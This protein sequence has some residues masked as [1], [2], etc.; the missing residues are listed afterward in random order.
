MIFRLKVSE[1]MENMYSWIPK[2]EIIKHFNTCIV[3]GI[4]GHYK[5]L[6]KIT[7]RGTLPLRVFYILSKKNKISLVIF[8][9]G[10]AISSPVLSGHSKVQNVKRVLIKPLMNPKINPGLI[11]SKYLYL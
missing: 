8:S 10:K 1:K 7:R 9:F 6:K 3:A 2:W 5:I 11:S 4:S